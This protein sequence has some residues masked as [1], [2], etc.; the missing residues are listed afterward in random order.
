M[1]A[2]DGRPARETAAGTGAAGGGQPPAG[3]GPTAE[4]QR[5]AGGRAPGAGD[6]LR[7]AGSWA[8]AV[9]LA[10]CSGALLSSAADPS[11]PLPAAVAWLPLLGA[12]HALAPATPGA[13]A[14]LSA[15]AWATFLAGDPG[16]PPAAVAATVLAAALAGAGSAT[17]HR[18]TSWR[19]LPLLGP[20]QVVGLE[21][22]RTLLIPDLPLL[23]GRH[24]WA[25][26]FHSHPLCLPLAHWLGESAPALALS[27]PQFL[28]AA[29]LLR[30][31]SRPASAAPAGARRSRPAPAAPADARPL[32]PTPGTAAGSGRP[33]PTDSATADGRP[34]TARWRPTRP[35]APLLVPLLAALLLAALV[36]P[37]A[38][39]LLPDG[40]PPPAPA[41]TLAAAAVQPGWTH[42]THP[43]I[44]RALE[45]G[46]A[47][48]AAALLLDEAETAARQASARGAALVLWPFDYLNLDP[49]ADPAVRGRLLAL[50]RATGAV[51]VVPFGFLTPGGPIHGVAVAQP[52]SPSPDALQ[53]R[54]LSR[55]G[56]STATFDWAGVLVVYLPL[57][58]EAGPPAP[59]PAQRSA[60]LR[61]AALPP[62]HGR[63]PQPPAGSPP[64]GAGPSGEGWPSGEG[65]PSAERGSSREGGP[66]GEGRPSRAGG[67]ALVLT[68]APPGFSP[69]HLAAAAG[70]AGVSVV[71]AGWGTAGVSVVHA[72]WGMPGIDG[73]RPAAG[74]RGAS[75][76]ADTGR[77]RARVSCPGPAVLVAAVSPGPGPT[78]TGVTDPPGWLG[79][80]SLLVTL[81]FP[82]RPLRPAPSSGR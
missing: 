60:A 34:R 75:L 1:P 14:V 16:V 29:C 67:P 72:G 9:V 36:A 47:R 21:K 63:P 41:G 19:L 46:D 27:F 76:T 70:A 3:G 32:H 44:R 2:A 79:L 4:G 68:T 7:R 65:T 58:G 13:S 50:A 49:S 52:R 11:L 56:P 80:L 64:G 78:P 69:L 8:A 77:A 12:L 17:L 66:S 23:L 38:A 53:V 45:Q 5:A 26:A 33:C 71:H 81:P 82:R 30:L 51:L 39:A 31:R 6:R 48:A 61:W 57:H 43:G 74:G 18:R 62:D 54:T 20:L 42:Y 25:A 15:L 55:G 35:A 73:D 37:W 24:S 40:S 22:L 59:P 10:A 28:L